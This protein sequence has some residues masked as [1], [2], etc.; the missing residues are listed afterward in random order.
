VNRLALGRIKNLR[1]YK[2]KIKRVLKNG[3][4]L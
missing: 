3:R 2:P 1:H 4:K